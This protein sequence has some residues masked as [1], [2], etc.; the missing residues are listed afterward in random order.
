MKRSFASLILFTTGVAGL[1]AGGTVDDIER[2]QGKWLVVSLTELGKAIPAAETN[3]LEFTIEKDVFTVVD[4]TPTKEQPDGEAVV[5]YKIVIDGAK[6]P[7]EINFTHLIG[8]NKG[9]TEPGIYQFEKNQLKLA[10]DE[11]RKGRPT[12]F[13]GK[14]TE[15][16]SVI[17]LKKKG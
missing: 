5:Q 9:K 12:V 4:K 11:S 1:F 6:T 13:E 2:M 16:Y 10:L 7:K 14:E 8:V 17:V 3:L 15:N